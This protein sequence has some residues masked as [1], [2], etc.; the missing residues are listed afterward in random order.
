MR[1]IKLIWAITFAT[2]ATFA[3]GAQGDIEAMAARCS[4]CHQ[5]QISLRERDPAELAERIR[6]IRDGERPH[7]PLGLNDDTDAG[8]DAIAAALS[9]AKPLAM[10]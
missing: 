8:I 4:M 5:G 3:S 2:L 6:A 1:L 9:E 10:P 7:R